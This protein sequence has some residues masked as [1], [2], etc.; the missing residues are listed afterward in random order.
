MCEC[1]CVCMSGIETDTS[2]RIELKFFLGIP[3]DQRQVWGKL[4]PSAATGWPPAASRSSQSAS[5][6]VGVH[7]QE[8]FIKQKL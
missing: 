2:G 8:K 7:F 1:V 4:Q 5:G 3:D 6:A